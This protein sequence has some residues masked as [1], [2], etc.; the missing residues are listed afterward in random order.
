MVLSYADVL[1]VIQPTGVSGTLFQSWC[2]RKVIP[3]DSGASEGQRGHR[4]FT[5][6]ETLGI[7]V[8]CKVFKTDR[9]CHTS[10]VTKIIESF[11]AVTEKWLV[12]EFAKGNTH[13]N[14][15]GCGKGQL[16]RGQRYDDQI[17]VKQTYEEVLETIARIEQ[18]LKERSG[19]GRVRG[20]ALN[21]T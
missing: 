10:F 1:E 11:G 5:L 20:L 15:P 14:Q 21:E 16:L 6:T 4:E 9:G 12:Q 19:P 13:L 18:R 17:D 8:A 3:I 2:Q 7:V